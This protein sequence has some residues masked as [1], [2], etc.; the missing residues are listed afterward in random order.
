MSGIQIMKR[1]VAIS[2][3]FLLLLSF[4]NFALAQAKTVFK[5][6]FEDLAFYI[7]IDEADL[8]ARLGTSIG[9]GN[10]GQ[11]Y[12]DSLH[13]VWVVIEYVN[14][15]A[16]PISITTIKPDGGAIHSLHSVWSADKIWTSQSEG[17]C[18]KL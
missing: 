3:T 7:T 17:A 9:I 10:F 16:L 12:F 15:G 4:T 5:C 11:A 1:L 8:T 18:L 2:L 13:K 14:M 6:K